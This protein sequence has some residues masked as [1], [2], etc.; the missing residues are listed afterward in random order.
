M[1]QVLEP[2]FL[3]ANSWMENGGLDPVCSLKKATF[4]AQ[5]CKALFPEAYALTYF[6]HDWI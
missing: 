6:A 3:F 5:A 1:Q 2:K 4:D